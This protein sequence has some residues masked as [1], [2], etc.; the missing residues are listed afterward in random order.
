MSANPAQS[1]GGSAPLTLTLDLLNKENPPLLPL[2]I[3][4]LVQS[5]ASSSS[6]S[7]SNG[8][9]VQEGAPGSEPQLS[10]GEK[11]SDAVVKALCSHFADTGLC[12]AN[13]AQTQEVEGYFQ[14]AT[15]I[16]GASFQSMG[17][18]ADDLDQHLALRTF[19]VAGGG[20]RPTAADAAVWA[21]FGT[22]K[23]A[24]G[25]LNKG[26][27]KHLTR[28]AKHLDV[29]PEFGGATQAIAAAKSNKER[30]REQSSGFDLFL[31]DNPAEGTVVTRFPPEPSG[32][33]HVGHAKAAILNQYFAKKYKGKLIVRF[34]D[35]NPSKEKM[36]FQTAIVEDLA[37]MGIHP[38]LQSHTSDWFDELYRQV[39]ILI[40]QGDA[41]CD[42]TP[43]EQ[44]RAERMDGIE[45]SRRRA[46]VEETLERFAEM[47]KGTEQGRSW[48]L[49]A[50][51]SVDN[52]NKAMRDPV[53][54]RCNLD[55]PHHRTGTKWKVYP[56][57]DFAAPVV[58][59]LEGVT[60]ALRTNE[61]HDR[62]PQ[63]AWFIEKLKLRNVQIWDFAR[64]NF[65]YT[66]LSKRKLQWFVDNGK[67]TGWDDPRFPTIRGIRRRGMTVEC[68]QQFI[69][70]TGPSQQ[71]INAE[72]DAIWSLNKKII[73]PIVPRYTAIVTD[74]LVRCTIRGAPAVYEKPAPKHKKNPELGTKTTVYGPE[75]YLEQV[76]A[77]SFADNEEI[78][79]MDVGNVFVR[80]KKLGADGKTIESLELE[81]NFSGDFTK[82]EKKVTWLSE[83]PTRPLTPVALLEFDYLITKKKLE[84]DDKFDD[85]L[86]PVTEFRE[87]ALAAFDVSELAEGTTIQFER[88]G[89]YILDKAQGKDG[90]RE[91]I[92]I[93]DG[94]AASIASKHAQSSAAPASTAGKAAPVE[95]AGKPKSG[96]SGAF[97]LGQDA[98]QSSKM[99][100]MQQ[101]AENIET[102][103]QS[104]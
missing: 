94:K 57:Y 76:D 42:D 52:P 3:V 88:K 46:T 31:G 2:A 28:W 44:M 6:S 98:T 96:T 85:F 74:G 72:W 14:L 82:T 95:A 7:S 70:A 104:E 10:T 17:P 30:N 33:L 84:E 69:L 54:Y 102:P 68:I 53:I 51:M 89:Y 18:L 56:T 67:V 100:K 45:S 99:Y 90:R 4:N 81:A 65:I 22:N 73:D 12:G 71:P 38:D 40:K 24:R 48:C 20:Y 66:L 39:I 87:E 97:E 78:T 15:Q 75:C 32:Y 49:R 92:K 60:H 41:Y 34:D 50:K 5:Q 61:Y 47:C 29:L 13:Q 91:F 1:G 8:I 23:V 37:L 36:E 35:T 21:A 16:L 11:G 58:D 43:Q 79:L 77:Q 62:N 103:V 86:T 9:T 80:G 25:V 26:T 64:L 27:H 93:P 59:S 101:L 55:V 19:L 63:Y 83:S